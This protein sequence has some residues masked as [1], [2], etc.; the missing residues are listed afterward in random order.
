MKITRVRDIQISYER[1]FEL[2]VMIDRSL[3]K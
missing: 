2:V 3:L 1:S